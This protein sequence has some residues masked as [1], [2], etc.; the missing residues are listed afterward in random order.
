MNKFISILQKYGRVKV[1][2]YYN[3]DYS[4][5][6]SFI[7]KDISDIHPIMESTSDDVHFAIPD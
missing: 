5:P 7:S 1:T 3:R 2:V 6:Y 4:K